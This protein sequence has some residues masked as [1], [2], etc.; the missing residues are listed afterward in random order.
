VTSVRIAVLEVL[1]G[2]AWME[3][4]R[5]S[6]FLKSGLYFTQRANLNHENELF[7]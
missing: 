1:G 5:T 2:R 7:T 4:V 3:V 6:Q